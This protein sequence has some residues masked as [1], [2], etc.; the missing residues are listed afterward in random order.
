MEPLNYVSSNG[1][2][3]TIN[4]DR[5]TIVADSVKGEF[6]ATMAMTTLQS[7]GLVGPQVD[8][9]V[10]IKGD[11]ADPAAPFH[12]LRDAARSLGLTIRPA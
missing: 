10:N 11:W 2:T 4:P 7:G 1:V 3:F 9:M 12:A 5:R 6:V 8:D